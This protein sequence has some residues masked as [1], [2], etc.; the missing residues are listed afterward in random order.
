MAKNPNHYLSS[1]FGF[2]A[3]ITVIMDNVYPYVSL[4]YYFLTF[5]VGVGT[6]NSQHYLLDVV[7]VVVREGEN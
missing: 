7:V 4:H 2:I 6:T 5:L 1:I 3:T